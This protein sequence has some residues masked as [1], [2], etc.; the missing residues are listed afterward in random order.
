MSLTTL[1]GSQEV[2]NN[3]L[4]VDDVLL[5]FRSVE[6][7]ELAIQVLIDV[8]NACII[9][10]SVAVVDSRPDCDQVLFREPVLVTLHDELVSACNQ[11]ET[12]QMI[13]L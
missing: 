7:V 12:V 10:A 2:R 1:P 4:I 11:V 5:F 9:S 8:Q 3:V 13:E 6:D